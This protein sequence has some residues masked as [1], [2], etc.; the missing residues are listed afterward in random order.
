VILLTSRNAKMDIVAGLQAGAND[1]LVKPYDRGE[2]Q[3]RIQVG[4][5]VVELQHSLAKQ[6]RDLEEALGQVKQL[7]TLLPICCYCKKIRDDQNYWGQV[8]EYLSKNSAVRFSHGICPDCWKKEV[9]PQMD[10]QVM[11]QMML[12]NEKG[13]GK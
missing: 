11:Q 5:T 7:Q 6:V 8:E 13:T 3:A 1:Y 12:L 10:P 4:R 9:E 2:L